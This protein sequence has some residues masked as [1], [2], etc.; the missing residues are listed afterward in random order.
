MLVISN[1]TINSWYCAPVIPL[2]SMIV[3]AG[4][5]LIFELLKFESNWKGY[6]LGTFF[7]LSVFYVPYKR[8]I[9]DE[10]YLQPYFQDDMKYGDFLKKLKSTRPELKD[11]FV[12]YETLNSHFLFY[13]TVYNKFHNYKVVGCG[14]GSL[15]NCHKRAQETGYKVMICNKGYLKET[16]QF[17]ETKR[18]DEYF[19]CELLEIISIKE[20]TSKSNTHD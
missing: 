7:A 10:V 8:I 3:G 15:E 6:L 18:I 13:R 5:Y 16:K 11:I 17:F 4:I 14:I 20:D 19:G 9:L 12:Y 2:L 1:G